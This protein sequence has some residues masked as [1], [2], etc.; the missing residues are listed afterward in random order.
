MAPRG[1]L[2]HRVRRPGR[3]RRRRRSASPSAGPTST[4]TRLRAGTPC[5]SRSSTARAARRLR[6]FDDVARRRRRR[7][8][9]DADPAATSRRCAGSS[10]GP[11]GG[12]AQ[13]CFADGYPAVT[14]S[15]LDHDRRPKAGLRRAARRL[16]A[17]DRRGRPA[18]RRRAPGDALAL[19][20]HVVSDR[21]I[22][23]TMR[24]RVIRSGAVAT[25]TTRTV[26]PATCRGRRA[27][28]GS[29]AAPMVVP[30][31][32]PADAVGS[33][34]GSHPG[35][36][37]ARS[38]AGSASTLAPAAVGPRWHRSPTGMRHRRR[39]SLRSGGMAGSDAVRRASWQC[40]TRP[41]HRPATAAERRDG[42]PGRSIRS[43]TRTSTCR[44]M[45]K[46]RGTGA[47]LAARV[48]PVGG[49]QE[50]GDG[51]HRH[52]AHGLRVRPHGRQPQDV[53][54]PAEFNAL[55]RVP[56]RAARADPAP[57]RSLLWLLRDR[58]DRAP[59]SST[60]T[61]PTRSRG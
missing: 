57:A 40:P 51:A 16:P 10:T 48:L 31:T 56:A 3:A 14:W 44:P 21:R 58:A 2:R 4:G 43:V 53:P 38:S 41:F 18:A 28:R 9:A 15:V 42:D 22:A 11:T 7:Y 35:R 24:H 39:D 12:F 1:P 55:R 36:P 32:S 6:I 19:D 13:F 54:G 26:G 29:A 5:R 30:A 46:R 17:R 52:R 8:Q 47:A 23:L 60:S 33:A 50:V 25:A 20:V 37:T 27:H 59:S 49:R 61:R 34:V 45:P